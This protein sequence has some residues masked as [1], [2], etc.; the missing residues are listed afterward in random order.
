MV[1]AMF[2]SISMAQIYSSHTPCETVSPGQQQR[3]SINM[4]KIELQQIINSVFMFAVFH[5]IHTNVSKRI[6]NKTRT[7][8]WIEKAAQIVKQEPNIYVYTVDEPIEF[9]SKLIEQKKWKSWSAAAS[10]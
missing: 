8:E 4:R 6:Q 10:K 7:G 5:E 2:W 1:Y 9:L 3:K